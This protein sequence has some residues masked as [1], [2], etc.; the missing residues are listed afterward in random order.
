VVDG[1]TA[2]RWRIDSERLSSISIPARIIVEA[3]RC[4][5]VAAAGFGG[6]GAF[7]I[8]AAVPRHV[9][10]VYAM[11]SM[12]HEPAP[13]F[14]TVSGGWRRAHGFVDRKPREG[15]PGTQNLVRDT[16]EIVIMHI[17][18][19]LGALHYWGGESSFGGGRPPKCICMMGYALPID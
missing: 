1:R 19:S 4:A 3:A 11:L 14:V 5:F 17:A 12:M 8:I 2:N 9:P 18:G 7:S 16:V 6:E 10:R 13:P 15:V